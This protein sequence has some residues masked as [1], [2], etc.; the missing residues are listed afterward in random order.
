[1]TSSRGSLC[2]SFYSLE[3][4][5]TIKENAMYDE[6]ENKASSRKLALPPPAMMVNSHQKRI[7]NSTPI[8]LLGFA[9]ASLLTGVLKISSQEEARVDGVF[10]VTAIFL[11]GF[12]QLLAAICDLLNNNTHSATAFG[13]YGLHW[14]SVGVTIGFKSVE[15]FSFEEKMQFT[16]NATYSGVFTVVTA[17]LLVPTLRMSRMQ[18]A[19]FTALWFV[20]LF[21]VP[22][23]YGMKWAEIVSGAFQCCAAAIGFYLA[24]LE[25]VNEAWERPVMSPFPH[26]VSIDFLRYNSQADQNYAP[27]RFSEETQ[28]DTTQV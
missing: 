13:I 1:M 20:F 6:F 27:G 3:D 15:E 24:T 7:G 17:V 21:E 8:G 25:L 18:T 28:A 9:V 4:R 5:I 23:A 10:F 2:H 11:G 26:R 19:L 12:A 16:S 22:A 14:I